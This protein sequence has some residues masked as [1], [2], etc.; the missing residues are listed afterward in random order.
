MKYSNSPGSSHIKRE[1]KKSLFFR[2]LSNLY[3]S[4]S[5]EEPGLSSVFITKVD[6]S[7]D[8]GI[9]YVYF[10]SSGG[11]AQ[12]K[13]ALQRLILYKPSMRSALAK[14]IP[15]RYTPDLQFRFDL[16]FEKEQKMNQ[17]L[18]SVKKDLPEEDPD[19]AEE[20]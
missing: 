18:D 13:I 8:T 12:F 3:Y 11:E 10:G 7:S 19:F 16:T 2:E 6:L 15:G 5:Q 9:C 4:V 14:K 1:Q 17:L 20:N